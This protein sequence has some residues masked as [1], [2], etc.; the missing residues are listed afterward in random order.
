MELSLLA[1][2]LYLQ[3][4][5]STCCVDN[6]VEIIEKWSNINLSNGVVLHEE[7][8][9]IEKDEPNIKQMIHGFHQQEI[10]G[11]EKVTK[12]VKSHF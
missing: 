1:L 3:L 6:Q 12:L 7:T 5:T 8:N 2:L 9:R 10:N 4:F 11:K